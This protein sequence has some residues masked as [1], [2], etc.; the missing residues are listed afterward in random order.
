MDLI[1][2]PFRFGGDLGDAELI[3][4]EQETAQVE[5][6]IR[7]GEKL[8]LIGPRR[9]GKT[10]ILRAAEE[11]LTA[12][13][14]VVLRL[15]AEAYP[16]LDTFVEQMVT[17]AAARL[18]GKVD[19][20]VDQLRRF[21]A[22]LRPEVNFD[23]TEH[24]WTATLG[25]RTAADAGERLQLLVDALEGLEKM[26]LAQPKTRPVGLIIDEFQSIIERG[27][28]TAEA[29]IR[30][31][32]QEHSRVG[33]VFAGSQTRL[34]TD[35]TMKA[36][37]PF[38]R[39]GANRFV[40]PLPRTDFARHLSA[41]FRKSGF[42]VAD[43]AAIESILTLAEDVPYN[44]QMLA[45]YC[46]EELRSGQRVR[47]GA[48]RKPS[49]PELTVA[50]VK[51]VLERTVRSLDPLFTQTWTKLTSVQQKTLLAVIRQRGTGMSASAVVRTIGASPSTVQS[52]LR[53]LNEQ[54]ILRDDPVAGHVRV[55]FEDPFFGHWIRLTVGVV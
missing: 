41:N 45:Y 50:M 44:V 23:I 36:D 33:Y 6:A 24:R 11:R 2:N 27:G 48:E 15:N 31:V 8:F 18:K 17:A 9:F 25:V 55:C 16:S 43:K 7:N 32:I 12:A 51:E 1:R 46:W 10:S 49:R 21:F 14:A 34:M 26:A 13:N 35:M 38:Y 39:L 47:G 37:R 42:S 22:K 52:A 19:L 40:G 4:R 28:S 53:S 5:S 30:S 20:V 29:Q 54:S 3:D